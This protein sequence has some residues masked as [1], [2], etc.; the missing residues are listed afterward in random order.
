MKKFL[1]YSF[2]LF[3][4]TLSRAGDS[5]LPVQSNPL[6]EPWRWQEF[7]ELNKWAIQDITESPDG[8]IWFAGEKT[9][10]RYDGISWTYFTQEHGIPE[11]TMLSIDC[12]K[13]GIIYAICYDKV[14]AY[15]D[16]KWE[17]IY[18]SPVDNIRCLT[19][20]RQGG[21]WVGTHNGIIL[22]RENR[23]KIYATQ[24]DKHNFN[25]N[26]ANTEFF[27]LPD[28]L[29][30]P[31]TWDALSGIRLHHNTYI[32]DSVLKN[33]PADKKGLLPGDSVL[34]VNG[35]ANFYLEQTNEIN[36]GE[37]V[38][39][40]IKHKASKDTSEIIIEKFNTNQKYSSI[41]C[42]F[43]FEGQDNELFYG[44]ISAK[45]V[46][47]SFQDNQYN[48][49][50]KSRIL[51][52]KNYHW[53]ELKPQIIQDKESIWIAAHHHGIPLI[54]FN[55]N[56]KEE[57]WLSQLGGSDNQIFLLKTIRDELLVGGYGCLQFY[58]GKEW[59][60]YRQ[61]QIPIPSAEIQAFSARDGSIWIFGHESEVLR[62]DYSNKRWLTYEGLNY[63][64]S[65]RDGTSWYISHEG[66][67]IQNKEENWI[68]HT[69]DDGLMTD[70]AALYLT[71]N[72]TV[73]AIG[74]DHH[75]ASTAMWNGEKWLKKNHTT[76]S[77]G[78]DYRAIFEDKDGLI[79]FGANI[80][81]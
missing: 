57:I 66:T 11:R 43:I 31:V 60:I 15:I 36:T 65:T 24:I 63:E 9:I 22:I 1:P 52:D 80:A 30:I 16:N 3:I 14:I 26:Q 51:L 44:L 64:C 29:G 73:W 32:I 8:H 46:R 42:L 21:A 81:N 13:N 71:R 40:F 49:I 72:Q 75:I 53:Y 4:F 37:K 28:S 27:I 5:Y 76:F 47:L 59:N 17:T 68:Q 48:V 18:T 38:H 10:I 55:K 23:F 79:W 56:K 2:I 50:S 78:I 67:V 25:V 34:S 12:D 62:L 54:H 70:P 33:S 19:A 35:V 7:P 39:L 77:W 58:N 45:S 61:P 6:L 69:P 20:C 74:S 41:N